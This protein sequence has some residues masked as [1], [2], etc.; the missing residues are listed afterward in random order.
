M[1]DVTSALGFDE[2]C[3]LERESSAAEVSRGQR[4]LISS[5]FS[6]TFPPPVHFSMIAYSESDSA[7]RGCEL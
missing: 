5:F 7:L 6:P 1:L 2:I 4:E 3:E